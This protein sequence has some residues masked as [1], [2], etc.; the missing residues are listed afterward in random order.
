MACLFPASAV[1]PGAAPGGGPGAAV[2]GGAPA[3][4]EAVVSP[5][6]G[7]LVR[8]RRRGGAR[9]HRGWS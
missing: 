8:G 9:A 7:A 5:G 4:P 1:R 6:V 3:G 2:S